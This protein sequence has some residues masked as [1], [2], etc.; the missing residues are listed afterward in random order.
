M[1]NSYIFVLLTLAAGYSA[2]KFTHFTKYRIKSFSGQELFFSSAVTGLFICFLG[3]IFWFPWSLSDC[4][5]LHQVL[6]NKINNEQILNIITGWI[7][8][9]P[10][11]IVANLFISNDESISRIIEEQNDGIQRLLKNSNLGDSEDDLVLVAITLSNDKVYI[12]IVNDNSYFSPNGVESFSLYVV[13]S[14]YRV[15]ETRELV[16]THEYADT[17]KG[18]RDAKEYD[19]LEDFIVSISKDSVV[20]VARFDFDIYWELNFAPE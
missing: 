15:A 4:C 7:L 12:G 18:Y 3:I 13:Y 9:I 10:L 6:V 14:G 5:N 17:I 19:K 2:L 8:S 11:V 20:S 16:V 1:A